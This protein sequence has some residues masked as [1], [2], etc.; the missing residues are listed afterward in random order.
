MSTHADLAQRVAALLQ[1]M[2]CLQ[3]ED[4]CRLIDLFVSYLDCLERNVEDVGAV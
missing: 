2:E 4:R 3:F 1:R